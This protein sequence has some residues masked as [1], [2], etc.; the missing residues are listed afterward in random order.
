MRLNPVNRAMN[1]LIFR[2]FLLKR[3]YTKAALEELV[4]GTR[5]RESSFTESGIGFELL[6]TK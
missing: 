4:A 3:A 6:L 2:F 1:R 5:F